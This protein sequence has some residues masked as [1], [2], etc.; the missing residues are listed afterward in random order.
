MRKK[1]IELR[2]MD[3][4]M[5]MADRSHD[6]SERDA[7]ET[8][9][10]ENEGACGL[11]RSHLQRDHC[12]LLLDAID[13]QLAPSRWSQSPSKDTSLGSRT[14][15]NDAPMSCLDF[16]HT[17][18]V[19]KTK[20][21]T[22]C[23]EHPVIHIESKTL[24]KGTRDNEEIEAQREQVIW[25]LERL[26]GD[27]CM[28]SRVAAEMQPPSDSVCTEDFV[29][30]FQEEMVE[31]AFPET[32]LKQLEIEDEA[33]RTEISHSDTFQSDQTEQSVFIANRKGP[34]MTWKSSEATTIGHYSQSSKPPQRKELKICLPENYGANTCMS[35]GSKKPGP[36]QRLKA[37]QTVDDKG[38]F[39][40]E[41]EDVIQHKNLQH[42]NIRSSKTKCLA[43]VAVRSADDTFIDSDLDSLCTEQVGQPG[44]Y[45]LIQA[46][47]SVD[48]FCTNQSDLDTP[49]QEETVCKA[50]CMKRGTCRLGCSHNDNN[51]DTNEDVHQASSRWKAERKSDMERT[52]SQQKQTDRSCMER[53][54]VIMSV[55]EREEIERQL[56]SAKSELFA[57]QRR[58][59]E[60]LESMQEKLEETCEELQRATD[61]ESSLRNTCFCLEEKQ[62]QQKE[63]IKELKARASELQVELGDCKRN[64]GTLE[65]MLGHKELQLMD[66]QKHLGALQAERDG[67][68][69]EL[70]HLK[71]QHHK[72]LKEAKDQTH[73][74]MLKEQ[75]AKHL[76]K[77][78]EQQRREAKHREEELHVESLKKVHKAI[79]E[80][81]EKWEAKKAEAVQVHYEILEEQNR[82]NLEIMK[83]EMEE[84]KSKALA[85]E[86]K[87]LELKTKVQELEK[88]RCAQQTEQ[89]SLLGVICKS[90]KEE[91]EAKLQI[92]QKQM[93]QESQR[94]V[95]R[96]ERAVQLAETEA[97][98]LRVILEERES[99][100]KQITA[101]LDQ[102][103]RSWTLELGAECQHLHLLLEKS[104]AKQSA[105]QL[106]ASVSVAEAL[107]NLR[108]LR[109]Q[110]KHSIIYL[111][112]ELDSQKQTAEQLRKDKERELSI[113][114]Q[115]LRMER[116]QA[117]DFLKERLIQEHMEELSSLNVV[118]MS[119]GGAEE[120]GLAATLCKQLKSK[121]LELR[122]VKR[123]VGQWK[124]QN[125]ARLPC[126]FQEV[127]TAELERKS[128]KT[129]LS[130]A[131]EGEMTFSS[132]A[133]QNLFC[134]PSLHAVDSA[135]SY[136]P[137]DKA[138]VKLLCYLRSR[139][140]QL[141]VENQAYTCSLSPPDTIHLDLDL[142][143]SCLTT[144]TQSQN[145]AGIPSQSSPRTV[146]S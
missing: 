50:Q 118:Y 12:D 94:T 39:S 38:N 109:E 51:K 41:T 81:R 79:T 85:I 144:I 72:T 113:Q 86:H 29:R 108:T 143:G 115:Q 103:L 25:R 1:D 95:L 47:R 53:K 132:K 112:H 59:R 19:E 49:T 97:D 35:H 60:Q 7:K 43:G 127:P 22:D 70:Q 76:R 142:S 82:K 128:S 64:V 104:G 23:P 31:L 63:Q 13:A 135:A 116:A 102:Q 44:W 110:L 33:Q 62:M 101:E 32:R 15:I 3:M 129:R 58:A 107:T 2:D 138:T 42:S 137:S 90:L 5:D 73:R 61:A 140:K 6:G 14:P 40:H 55:L 27:A 46:V 125:A 106:P 99:S 89:D 48:D 120:G 87:V 119:D 146:S 133:H 20:W 88:E 126:E 98:R 26:L 121:D 71:T 57:E 69:E 36:E 122:Q 34:V 21:N 141:R 9:L 80:E 123:N 67:L 45:A 4:D 131:P 11:D 134:S 83:S 56:D 136:S 54:G 30:R 100:H 124:E 66:L 117:M 92:L 37:P 18:T 8:Q 91:H 84:E 74:I 16:I 17:P 114:R 77:S 130:E 145:S 24:D 68:K 75:E 139:V 28:G 65:K 96:L 93:A 78:L 111:Q 52:R 105:M 10:N